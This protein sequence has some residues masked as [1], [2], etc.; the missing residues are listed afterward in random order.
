M[1]T[2][3]P[4]KVLE[5]FKKDVYLK[6]NND[7]LIAI[8]KKLF[9]DVSTKLTIT[10]NHKREIGIIN[11][12]FDYLGILKR[13]H[14]L[15]FST[16]RN[17]Q[18]Q[19]I[20]R[21]IKFIDLHQVEKA[22][23]ALSG[24]VLFLSKN[25]TNIN[26]L[27]IIC[28]TL[29]NETSLEDIEANYVNN[30][31]GIMDALLSFDF[32][33][34]FVESENFAEIGLNDLL[35]D[36]EIKNPTRRK[37]MFDKM[38]FKRIS[39]N[40]KKNISD[41]EYNPQ[42]PPIYFLNNTNWLIDESLTRKINFPLPSKDAKLIDAICKVNKIL[43][44]GTH[45]EQNVRGGGQDNQAKDAA[46]IFQY[47][48]KVLEKVKK[49]FKVEKICLC[50]ILEAQYSKITSL[51]WNRIFKTINNR[52]NKNKYLLNAIQFIELIKSFKE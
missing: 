45:K 52:N 16:Q 28:W 19:V 18:G 51:H 40:I 30:K 6:A 47:K 1:T 41:F 15:S 34:L 31:D 9:Q 43:L 5:D 29:F 44:I 20:E 42:K 36:I 23:E 26:G 17:N 11:N 38:I 27:Q 21:F 8:Y 22:A 13:R 2:I 49:D 33:S 7:F 37:A 39:N 32:L 4:Q 24:I 50:I 25:R 48:N 3:T 10:N 14:K 46:T 35:I 12:Y